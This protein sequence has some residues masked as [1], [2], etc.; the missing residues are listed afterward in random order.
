MCNFLLQPLSICSVIYIYL[1]LTFSSA[2]AQEASTQKSVSNKT[3]NSQNQS[4]LMTREVKEKTYPMPISL[5]EK[6]EQ[7]DSE[8]TQAQVTSVSQLEDVQVTDWAFQVLQSLVERY[9]CP[10]RQD[11]QDKSLKAHP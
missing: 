8:E 1:V 5:P 7:P 2:I 9:R 6:Q 11:L 4:R 3:S 10:I